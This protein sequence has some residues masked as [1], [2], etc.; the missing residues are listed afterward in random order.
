MIVA[1]Q[2]LGAVGG[3]LLSSLVLDVNGSVPKSYIPVLAPQS[4][5]VSEGF[6][7]FHEDV[8]LF[9]SQAICTMIFV[10][11]ILIL[12]GERTAP[13]KDLIHV[14][15][16]V[17]LTL[18]GLITLDYHTGACFNPAVAISQTFFQMQHLENTNS[19]LS[20]YLYGY[21][22]GPLV[23]GGVAGL[24]FLMHEKC[25]M[26]PESQQPDLQS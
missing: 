25:H 26:E 2:C 21:T 11:V 4:T 23:G 24:F 15:L 16:T 22:M 6:N 17:A 5:I 19:W 13:T 14:G 9:W 3:A 7:G 10:S 18:W 8:Q 1:A 20:H 12:K